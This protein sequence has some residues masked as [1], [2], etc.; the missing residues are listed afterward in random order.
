MG[1]V[2]EEIQAAVDVEGKHWRYESEKEGVTL[3]IKDPESSNVEEKMWREFRDL[4]VTAVENLRVWAVQDVTWFEAQCNSKVVCY[5]CVGA[6]EEMDKYFDVMRKM[7]EGVVV[8]PVVLRNY[9]SA[10]YQ[11]A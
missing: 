11:R 9:I 8:Q 4:D 6:L 5:F 10:M 7:W 1:R 2:F 3:F